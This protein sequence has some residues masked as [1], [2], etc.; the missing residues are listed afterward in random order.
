MKRR[1]FVRAGATSIAA[2]VLPR[3][4]IAQPADARVLRFEPQSNLTLL[5]DK[6]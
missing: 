5:V 3:F 4:A 6:I 1:S 2:S